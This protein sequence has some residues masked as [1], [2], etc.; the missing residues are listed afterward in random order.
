MVNQQNLI[1]ISSAEE[2][3]EKGSKGGKASVE[4]RR[5]KKNMQAVMQAL[6]EHR[7]PLEITSELGMKKSSSNYEALAVSML[8]KAY[9]DR[10]VR[11]A[12]FIRDTCGEKPV[13]Q[14][15]AEAAVSLSPEDISL[16]Q[17]VGA[18]LDASNT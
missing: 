8:F 3:R 10:D 15:K 18:R 4:A 12:E 1:P 11:A 13:A 2:A 5:K 7:A 14:V 9:V 16:L 6:M 17:K